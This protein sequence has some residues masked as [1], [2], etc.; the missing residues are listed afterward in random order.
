M[1]P[2]AGSAATDRSAVV[3]ELAKKLR[4]T[5][6][7]RQPDSTTLV[8][9]DAFQNRKRDAHIPSGI[10]ALDSLLPDGGFL[11]GTIVEWV[12]DE[13]GSGAQTLAMLSA[14]GILNHA[15][16]T[17]LSSAGPTE[18]RS[19]KLG[20]NLLIIDAAEDFYPVTAQQ[21]G[22]DL[23]KTVVVRPG[24]S[25]RGATVGSGGAAASHSNK[26][27]DVLWTLEQALR[28]TAIGITMCAMDHLNSHTYRR[29]QLA[30]QAG[31]GL[32]FLRRPVAAIR[33][34]TW[35]D[36]RMQVRS[37]TSDQAWRRLTVELLKGRS[38]MIGE[39][40]E[41]DYHDETNDVRLAAELADPTA[42]HRAAGA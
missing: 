13:I 27:N 21:L 26:N 22:V 17:S 1:S 30:V 4:Q 20:H 3:R 41:L 35:A 40:V 15:A 16:A 29:L 37:I 24:R 6:R 32:C 42:V 31:G 28:S 7:T 2:D 38:G 11:K 9:V 10:S 5:Q 8:D 39:T 12:C 34:P 33:Q 36:V 14:A 18:D 23:N 25:N 19:A